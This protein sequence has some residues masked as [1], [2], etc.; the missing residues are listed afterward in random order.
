METLPKFHSKRISLS[1]SLLLLIVLLITACSG[2]SGS[3]N[4]STPI[5]SSVATTSNGTAVSTSTPQVKL[6]TQPCPDAVKDP[7]YWDPI[8]GTQSGVS[9][10]GRVTCAN[11]IGQPSLQALILVGYQGTGMIVD[12]YVYNNI[13]DPRPKQLF[14]LQSLYKGDVLVS[15]YNT[16]ITAEVDQ[17]S[18]INKGQ[19]N[20]RL[21]I[22]LYREFKWSDGAG[23]LVPVTFPGIYPD[24]TRYQAEAVQQ[25]VNQGHEPWRLSATQ[26]SQNMATSLLKWTA[27]APATI[28]SGGGQHD[29]DAVVSVKSP[30]PGGSTITVTLNR[31][32][33]NANGGIWE[34]TLVNSPGMSIT[35]PQNRDRLSSP[36]TV[37]GSGN[38]FEGVIGKVVILDHLY[39][40][41]GHANASGTSGSNATF[42]TNVTYNSTFKTG[43][44]EGVLALFSY[45][46]A[47]SAITGAVMVKEML[48]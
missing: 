4:N 32:E 25:Q 18:S 8:V 39:T 47:N 3:S 23:T 26:T 28:T 40:D 14:K 46:A 31:L 43:T 11:L 6:G 42:T 36:T 27:N 30:F 35:R 19:P 1:A 33:G 10:V 22:D 12:A 20:A 38:S 45:G 29:V 17:E 15:A 24:L 44:Q 2:N 7:S 5:A 13:T 34:A 9:K 48:S 41:I 21:T 16:V 37:T